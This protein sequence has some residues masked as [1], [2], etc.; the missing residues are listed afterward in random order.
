MSSAPNLIQVGAVYDGASFNASIKTSASTVQQE[1]AKMQVSFNELKATTT[2]RINEIEAKLAEMSA[3]HVT[4]AAKSSEAMHAMGLSMEATGVGISRHLR[5][6]I[7]EVPILS[8]AFEALLPA[9]AITAGIEILTKLGE[10]ISEL[11]S[12]TFIFTDAMKAED[13][14]QLSLNKKWA[15]G[16]ERIKQIGREMQITAATT[17]AAKDKL[18][19][20]FNLE[21]LGGNSEQIKARLK[22]ITE[23][24]QKARIEATKTEMAVNPG[25]EY[26]AGADAVEVFTEAAIKAQ[27]SLA[28]L[29]H[30][31]SELQNSLRIAEALEKQGAQT[32]KGDY[33]EQAKKAEAEQAKLDAWIAHAV[34]ERG[35]LAGAVKKYNEDQAKYDSE[36]TLALAKAE[37]ERI[38]KI[39]EAE[40]EAARLKSRIDEATLEIAK[41][42]EAA[43]DQITQQRLAFELQIGKISESQYAKQLQAQLAKT[44]ETERA[45]LQAKRVAAEGNLLEQKKIDGEL[46]KLEDKYRIDSER[47]EQQG[48]MRRTAMA[49]SAFQ[50]IGS[51]FQSEVLG[52]LQ[53]TETISQAVSKMYQD[54]ILGLAQYIIQK[55]EKKAEEWAIDKLFHVHA[56]TAS[57]AASA[58]QSMAAGFASV[59]EAL[60]FPANVAAA[61]S[62]AAAAGAQTTAFGLSALASFDIGTNFVPMTGL[63][64]VHQGEK[65]IPASAQGPGYSGGHTL[66]FHYHAVGSLTGQ[67]ERKE[68][69]Q[70]ENMVTRML[71]KRG[72]R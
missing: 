62:V 36:A 54:L 52:I 70:F 44:V 63:A 19:L 21:D 50:Q 3:A 13:A 1:L 14:A 72:L 47:A 41:Q 49:R 7:A 55:G 42:H 4:H 8:K 16:A 65:I 67:I 37:E 24:V 46:R 31:Q 22:E 61:P 34:R 45:I 43:L 10:K 68:R 25:G 48:Y 56:V 30:E 5:G 69:S 39:V 9:F 11:I 28:G 40:K 66:N 57:T 26:A 64:L 29:N 38:S 23:A 71:K 51:S 15:E 58:G 27:E 12:S 17:E 59:M 53:G 20:Q 32:L 6:I 18:R 2:A 35:K 33:A 60:P